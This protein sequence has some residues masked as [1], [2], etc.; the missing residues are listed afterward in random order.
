MSPPTRPDL[1]SIRLRYQVADDEMIDYR[2]R[3]AGAVDLPFTASREITRTEGAL[4][5]G[6]TRREGLAGLVNFARIGDTALETAVARYPDQPVPSDIPVRRQGEWQG[7]DGHRDAFRHAYWNAL[8]AQ[9]YGPG[10]TSVF[11]T[12]H[13]AAPGNEANREAMDL[14]NNRVGRTIGAAHPDASP[15]QLARLVQN[16][17]QDGRLIVLDRTGALEWSDRVRVGQHGLTPPESIDPHLPVPRPGP[18][19][20]SL[21]P[22]PGDAR[23]AALATLVQHPMYLQAALALDVQELDPR[24]AGAVVRAAVQAGLSSV[25]RV[26]P[27]DEVRGADGQPTRHLFAFGERQPGVAV[28]DYAQVTRDA[29]AADPVRLATDINAADV[30][31]ALATGAVHPPERI[32]LRA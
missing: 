21:A 8:M 25:D 27:G 19:T 2:P 20:S 26:Q 13:E 1:Q 30:Q 5:D 14:Y 12:A 16:A 17:V 24:G 7:N 15:E 31:R 18:T 11:A 23:D 9:E 10:W 4:L 6:L 22:A 29:L 3:L 28:R 32:A